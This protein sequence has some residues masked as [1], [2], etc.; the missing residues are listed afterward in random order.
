M[1]SILQKNIVIVYNITELLKYELFVIFVIVIFE[2]FNNVVLR[3]EITL[4]K[5]SKIDGEL[6]KSGARLLQI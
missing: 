2:S 1:K 3:S 6:V 4:L 5:R